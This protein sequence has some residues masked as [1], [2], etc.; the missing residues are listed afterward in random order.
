MRFSS[1]YYF[2]SL[3]HIQSTFFHLRKTSPTH[4]DNIIISNLYTNIIMKLNI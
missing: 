4:R 2:S 1:L 3:E